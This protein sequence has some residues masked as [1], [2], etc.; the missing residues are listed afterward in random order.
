MIN[1]N[2]LFAAAK[3]AGIAPFEARIVTKSKLSVTVFDGELENYTIADDG[4]LKIRGLVVGKCG[5]FTSDR[6]DDEVINYAIA[7]LKQSAEYG[8]ALDPELFVDGKKYKYEKVKT[9]NAALD[10][11]SAERFIGVAKDI[12]ASALKAD[13]RIEHVNVE[14]EYE[15]AS[16][17]IANDN[18]LDV[19]GKTN[20][21][22]VFASAKAK[23]DDEIQSGSHYDIVSD[24]DAFDSGAFVKELVEKTIAQ[25]GGGSV[26]T[27]KYKVVYSPDCVALLVK[28]LCDGFSAFKA[29]KN[30]SL[31]KDKIG[32]R[33]FSPL[34]NIEQTP[35]GS[36]VFC[37]AFDDEGV[38]CRNMP[39]IDGG[40]PTGFVYDLETAK[41]AGVQST[42]NGTLVGGNVR[43]SV[44]YVTVHNGGMTESELFAH[45]GDGLY[46]TELGGAHAGLDGQSGNYSLQ[47]SGFFIKNGKLGKPV[48]LMTVA[49]NLI[50]DFANITAVGNN[51]KLTYYAVKTPS[52]A[53]AE[54]SVSGV[55]SE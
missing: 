21:V 17:R 47:A 1:I 45:V 22:T 5:T 19:S 18:G 4:A 29:E 40:T 16:Q 14:L 2:K 34:L 7:A 23:G 36:D 39:L 51:E 48:S 24:F 33:V 37:S 9:H 11:V 28:T 41:R 32:K 35:I 27:G 15:C 49:G 20:Y 53:I 26:E 30:M 54:L 13:S 31:L 38:P 42:G 43:P 10:K 25:L 52:V 46:I 50:T 3:T 44:G 8:N 12:A 55:K 6:V